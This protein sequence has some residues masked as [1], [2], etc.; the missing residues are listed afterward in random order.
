MATDKTSQIDQTQQR[1][2]RYV[3]NPHF[4]WKFAAW[5]MAVVFAAS[6]SMGT[7]LLY[8]LEAHVRALTLGA[9]PS[10]QGRT[11]TLL[12]TFALVFAAV[13]TLAFGVWSL[14]LTRR[15]CG[16][17]LV[18]GGYLRELREGR[19]PSCRPLRSS[20]EFKDFYAEFAQTVDAMRERRRADV[21]ALER[22]LEIAMSADAQQGADRATLDALATE[23][24]DLRD[25]LVVALEDTSSQTGQQTAA[26]APAASA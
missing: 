17:L 24:S 22:A 20:D 19:Y 9:T 18:I 13:T 8:F 2:R 6:A 16:P 3:V 11:V 5:L 14:I 1:R 7:I 15:F 25:E 10:S 26:Q 4:Q 23:V 21:A 12:C